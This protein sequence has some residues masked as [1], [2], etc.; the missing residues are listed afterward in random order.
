MEK[1]QAVRGMHDTLPGDALKWRLLEQTVQSVLQSYCYQEIRLPVI[2]KTELFS[3]SIGAGTDIVNKEMYTFQDRNG[4][5]LTLRPEGTAGCVRALLQHGLIYSGPQR[6]WYQGPMF[7]HERPQKGRQRQFYQIGA[8][9]FGIESAEIDAEIILI[10]ARIWNAL[11]IKD[12]RLQL[13]SLG[14]YTARQ[15]YRNRLVDYLSDHRDQLDEDSINRLETNPLRILDSKN[16]AMQTLIGTAPSL[17]DSIDEESA[18]HFAVLGDLLDANGV[19]YEINPRLVRGLDYYN[20]TVFEW[21]TDRLGAQGTICAGGRYDDL[22]AQVGGKPTP[23]VGFAMGIERILELMNFSSA[24]LN[25]NSPRIYQVMV[26]D[27]AMKSGLRLAERLRDEIP[28]LRLLMHSGGGS[29]KSQFKK[30]DKSQADYALILGADEVAKNTVQI[31]PLREN[32]EQYEI[33]QDKLVHEITS[34]LLNSLGQ[35]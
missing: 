1:L 24:E 3:R 25:S 11:G 27:T 5:F 22:V 13:N 9:A 23:A 17:L 2:E 30:A 8:E 34:R 16:P 32:T 14:S 10:C 4:E 12:V 18:Q 21:A 20:R 35:S 15:I 28:G 6:I 29:F 19:D 33:S 7:R 26:G 31:K